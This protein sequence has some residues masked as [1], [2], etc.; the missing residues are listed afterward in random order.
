MDPVAG[1]SGLQSGVQWRDMVDQI[2][3]I[4]QRRRL[5]PLSARQK[6]AT[7][8]STAWKEYG[9]VA[10][11]LRDAARTLRDAT[12]FDQFTTKVSKSAESD[13]ELLTASAGSTAAPGRYEVEVRA[14]ARAEKL[15]SAFFTD[16]SVARGLSG[17]VALNGQAV[18]IATTDSLTAIRDKINALNGGTTPTGVT[19]TLLTTSA[20]T[21]LVLTSDE[22]GANGIDTVDAASGVLASLGIDDGTTR[23]NITADGRTQSQ[24]VSSTTAAIATALGIPMPSPSTIK[25]GGQTITVDLAVD[26]LATIAARIVSA[27]G[28]A[29]SATV[30]SESVDGR[31][32]YRL[33]TNGAVEADGSV[34]LAA[35]QR[36][37]AVLG[38]TRASR[39][40]IAQTVASE[41]SFGDTNT[42]GTASTA[43]LLT[44]LSVN[45]QSL[46]LAVGDV[47]NIGGRAGDGSAITR[48]ITI[49][50]GTTVQDLLNTMNSGTGSFGAATRSATAAL[51]SGRLAVT[52]GSAGDSQLAAS[53]TVT[54]SGGGTVSLGAFSTTNG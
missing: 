43:T 22:T 16:A 15:G 20:G 31:T 44:N 41:N 29:N 39:G 46:A 25:V 30:T 42:A 26:S 4:E 54:R 11:K 14:L 50:A 52:D 17:T 19:A 18:T 38:F 28:D 34:N 9:A 36:A 24:R 8:A 23:A 49:G 27:T 47:V 13:R 32:R 53:L 7:E 5:D 35:S 3:A 33:V 2:M 45:G 21:R 51:T 1:F 6:S 48:T 40:A 10:T 12:A 37:L